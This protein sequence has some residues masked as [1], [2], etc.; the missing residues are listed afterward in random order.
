MTGRHIRV[1]FTGVL[2][3]LALLPAATPAVAAPRFQRIEH[4]EF[5]PVGTCPNGDQIVRYVEGFGL[6]DVDPMTGERQGTVHLRGYYFNATDDNGQ[7]LEFVRNRLQ[8]FT[9]NTDGSTTFVEAGLRHII[10][11]PGGGVIYAATGRVVIQ[12]LPD[13]TSELVFQAGQNDQALLAAV[14]PYLT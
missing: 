5:V 9:V 7:R 4:T 8:Q 6:L 14:C 12:T 3:L 2:A 1:L 11:A 13:G 10:T